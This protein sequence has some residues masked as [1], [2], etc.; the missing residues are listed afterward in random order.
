MVQSRRERLDK[1]RERQRRLR[2]MVKA[3]RRPTRDD[4]ARTL[5]HFAITENIRRGREQQW[6][7]LQERIVIELVTLE[8]DRRE[9]KAV[10]EALADKYRSG[11]T[12][13]RKQHLRGSGDEKDEGA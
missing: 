12:F 7:D 3:K 13:Q 9:T 2:A 10:R 6:A 1:Q 4:V 11:W 5:L 8:F